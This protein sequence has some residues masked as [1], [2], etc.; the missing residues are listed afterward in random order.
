MV[1]TNAIA[2]VK[3][4]FFPI[5]DFNLDNIHRLHIMAMVAAA[6]SFYCDRFLF[7]AIHFEILVQEEKQSECVCA[8]VLCAFE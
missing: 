7:C 6:L 3:A 8:R 2:P 5:M 1:M 4:I